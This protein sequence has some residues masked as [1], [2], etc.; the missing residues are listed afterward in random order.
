MVIK[1][2]KKS[3]EYIK[4]DIYKH[5]PR[6]LSLLDKA[7]KL[8]KL[9]KACL[10]FWYRFIDTVDHA[11]TIKCMFGYIITQSLMF[12]DQYP[13]F[14]KIIMTKLII[15][16]A[17]I[18]RECYPNITQVSLFARIIDLRPIAVQLKSGY[19]LAGSHIEAQ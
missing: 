12:Y 5:Y 17:A 6:I 2:L 18:T 3:L 9:R 8:P 16:K 4:E 10:E 1:S 19:S 15:E 7:I 14:T 11:P 13:S